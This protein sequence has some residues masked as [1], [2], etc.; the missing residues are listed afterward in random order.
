LTGSPVAGDI[1]FHKRYPAPFEKCSRS[2]AVWAPGRAVKHHIPFGIGQRRRDWRGSRFSGGVE[3]FQGF[4]HLEELFV[5]GLL[6]DGVDVH[7]ADHAHLIDDEYGSLAEA[8][9]AQDAKSLGNLPVRVEIAQQR[10]GDTA[11]TLSPC[12]E[13]GDA[14]NADTQDLGLDPI[15]PVEC[16]LVGW[17][18][19]RSY[20]RPG[21]REK[22]QNHI[23]FSMVVAQ[24]DG[25]SEVTFQ[26][27]FRSAL[28]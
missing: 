4:Q 18:L 17:D 13:A 24:P 10:E 7:I 28:S 26:H 23:A 1:H 11:Q 12:L 27:Q 25:L 9:L 2:A 19:A 14:V 21:K 8:F 15:E 3:R 5:I 22:G 6:V 16:G 20:G